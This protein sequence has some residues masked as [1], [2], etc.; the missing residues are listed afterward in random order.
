MPNLMSKFEIPMQ[1]AE[2]VA[3]L[4]QRVRIARIRRGWSVADLASKAGINR[5]TL[6][7]LELGKPGTAVGVCFT[8][9]WALGLDRTLNGVAD[10]DADLH[11]KALEAARRPT[12]GTQVG[13]FRYG[14]RYLAR[15][16]AV[17]FDPFRLPLAKQVFEFTQLKGIPGAVRD[18]APDAWGRRVIEH[19]LERD[20]ADLQEIDYLLHGPQDG[21]GYLSFG[22]K[23]E[24]PA[25]SRSYNRT[26]QLDELIA[27]SQAIEEGKRVAAHWLEQLDP[28]T[29]MGGARPKATIED[30][31]CLW[32]GKFP[33][34]DDRFNL[35]R[36]EFATLDL[37]SRCGLNV[38]QAWLQPVGSSDVLMLKRFD[39]EHAEGGYLRFGLVSG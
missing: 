19:K 6:A 39:R 3:Q 15:P 23:A 10:P 36:V 26:H 20:P 5:N 37:A 22:L 13:R 30:D 18:A 27:A 1:V 12:H 9:L 14:D 7:A 38:T 31:H 17:A 2:Q 32:L 35:Q 11:G 28:G 34:K 29:S 24:P 33:A 8:V 21:A 4:G 25:P 16:D